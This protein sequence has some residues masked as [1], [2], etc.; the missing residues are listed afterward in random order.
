MSARAAKNAALIEA[1]RKRILVL[2]GSWG[3]MIQRRKLSE[4]DSAASASPATCRP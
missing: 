4:A 3:V 2:D 1:A